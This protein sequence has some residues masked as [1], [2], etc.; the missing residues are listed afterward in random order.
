MRG[1]EP[2]VF[3]IVD[4]YDTDTYRAVYTVKLGASLYMLHALMKKSKRG[5]A[6]P[7]REIDLIKARLKRAKTMAQAEAHNHG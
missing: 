1:I 4:D 3:E 7:Q 2:G 5:I 6:I